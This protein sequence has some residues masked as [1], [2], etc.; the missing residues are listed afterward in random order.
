MMAEIHATAEG[1]IR[2]AKTLIAA[3]ARL[4]GAYDKLTGDF[5]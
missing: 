1:N 4:T 3:L 2:A 5:R